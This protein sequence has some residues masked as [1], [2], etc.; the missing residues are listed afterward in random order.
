MRRLK[1][2][3]TYLFVQSSPNKVLLRKIY[4][5]AL[6]N[7]RRARR[8]PKKMASNMFQRL[9]LLADLSYQL[10]LIGLPEYQ[11]RI[12]VADW[13]SEKTDEDP[14]RNPE[15]REEPFGEPLDEKE[16]PQKAAKGNEGEDEPPDPILRLVMLNHWMFTLGDRDC[17]PSVPHGHWNSKTREWPKLNPYNGR[18]FDHPHR[19]NTRSR[20]KKTD[21]Q[22]LWR[23]NSFIDHCRHQIHWYS[24]FAPSYIYPNARR[25]KYVFPIW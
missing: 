4:S 23:D 14:R 3:I 8:Q 1:T 25:G 15:D 18:V 17:Y 9:Y 22:K 16:E 13:L 7:F 10:G 11:E 20:L 2:L 24:S 19:E 12:K 5:L 21:M 6:L